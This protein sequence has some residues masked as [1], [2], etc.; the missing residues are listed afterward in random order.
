MKSPG[1]GDQSDLS[2]EHEGSGRLQASG[3]MME[4]LTKRGNVG[5]GTGLG[6]GVQRMNHRA[7]TF[8]DFYFETPKGRTEENNQVGEGMALTGSLSLF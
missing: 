8:E 5:E 4:S 1:C 2:S 3:W 7:F 6:Q